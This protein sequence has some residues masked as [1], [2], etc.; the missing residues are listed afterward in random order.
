MNCITGGVTELKELTTLV[1]CTQKLE[2]AL[3]DDRDIVHF[4]NGKGLIS[5]DVHSDVIE[6]TSMLSR[7]AK[8]GLVVDAIK[9]SVKRNCRNYYILTNYLH[10]D[11]RKYSDIISILDEEFQRVSSIQANS[12]RYQPLQGYCNCN[13]LHNKYNIV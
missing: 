10:Q 7:R 5:D 1:N 11:R 8:A 12:F 9:S 2:L 6:P 3:Q 4:L 13:K